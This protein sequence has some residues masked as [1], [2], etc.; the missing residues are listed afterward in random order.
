MALDSKESDIEQL[1]C[2]L[3]TLSVHSLDTTS[4]S[5]GNDLDTSEG[6][7]GNLWVR[8][9]TRSQRPSGFLLFVFT[10]CFELPGFF[11]VSPAPHADSVFPP[12]S[13]HFH[14]SPASRAQCAL[15]T[16][17]PPNLCP[18]PTSEHTNPSASTRG[19]ACTRLSLTPS[20]RTRMNVTGGW[21]RARPPWP[22]PTS[23]PLRLNLEVTLHGRPIPGEGRK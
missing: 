4:I 2:Q 15:L 3:S 7:P 14:L 12:F 6:Y 10:S 20:L 22:S 16:P 8:S 11:S 17:T 5:S 23:S 19:L 21:S 1:R 9:Q 13:S 18:S